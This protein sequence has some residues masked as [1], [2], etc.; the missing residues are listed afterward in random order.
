MSFDARSPENADP[1]PPGSAPTEVRAQ[2]APPQ[3][4]LA[5]PPRRGGSLIGWAI[6]GF[7][8]VGVAVVAVVGYLLLALG[9]GLLISGAILALAPLV[10][11]L[12]GVRWI[13]RWEPEPR[14]LLAFGFLWGA[15]VSIAVTLL[16]DVGIQ[17]AAYASGTDPD[18]S[19]LLGG[20]V[21]APVVEE[22]AKGLGVLLIF[23]V[24][25]RFFDGPVDGIVYAAVVAAGFAFTENILYFADSISYS[26]FVSADVGLTFFVRGILSPFAHAMFTS[27]TGLFIGL[28]GRRGAA[29]GFA[30]F[31]LG[32]VPAMLLHAVWNALA[33]LGIG[34]WFVVYLVVQVPLFSAAIVLILR[35]RAQ[36]VRLTAERL[37]EYAAVGWLSPQEVQALATP[38]G[39]RH[40]LEWARANRVAP[41]MHAYIRAATALAFTRQRIVSGRD[42]IGTRHDERRDLD[43]LLAARQAL[44][45]AVPVR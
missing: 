5:E 39:R 2:A 6:A 28:W 38:A 18:A 13:D 32:L 41:Q 4:V 25:R 35:L 10:I 14:A 20:I 24:A 3:P 34:G 8:V 30:G 45:A 26:G 43:R 23:L 1:R 16:I 29:G 17:L 21:Q 7:G 22:T 19:D 9:P 36:E 31:L 40:V 12:L 11:V 44:N 15:G 42:D 27:M 33:L 37:A